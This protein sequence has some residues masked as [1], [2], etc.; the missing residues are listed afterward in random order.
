MVVLRRENMVVRTYRASQRV[1][2]KESA[3][4][5]LQRQI[6]SIQG[7][8]LQETRMYYLILKAKAIK[9]MEV[10]RVNEDKILIQK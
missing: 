4:E 5:V 10:L 3:F 7:L 6:C 9:R 1:K 2:W 8:K